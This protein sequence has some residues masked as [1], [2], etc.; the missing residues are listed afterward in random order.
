MNFALGLAAGKIRGVKV[1]S[2]ILTTQPRQ[3]R[4]EPHRTPTD[5]QQ[6]LASSG[7]FAAGRRHFQANARYDQQATGRPEDHPATIG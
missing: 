5:A 7:R 1:D 4:M 6:T 3:D 2:A